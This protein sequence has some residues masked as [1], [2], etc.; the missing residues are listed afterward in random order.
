MYLV[1]VV[2]YACCLCVS[3]VCL[4]TYLWLCVACMCYVLVF[5]FICGM[6]YVVFECSCMVVWMD[7]HIL[8]LHVCVFL[9]VS[10]CMLD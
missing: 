9:C 7:V 3:A 8:A 5:A 2:Y 1:F 4:C 10:V 6:Q